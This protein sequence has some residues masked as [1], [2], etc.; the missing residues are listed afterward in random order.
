MLT[1]NEYVATAGEHGKPS[2]LF[3]VTVIV[4]VFPA[5]EADG[6]YVNVNG[7]VADE[8]RLRD[9]PPLL[10]RDTLVAL[11]PKRLPLTVM[12]EVPQ[13]LPLVDESVTVGGLAHPHETVKISPVVVQ[14]AAFLTVIL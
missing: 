9:P 5:S 4:I 12:D 10:E 8:G 11:P 6:V 14:P 1:F 3:V 2:G 7:E 13:V